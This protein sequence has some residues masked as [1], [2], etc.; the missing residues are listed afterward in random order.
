MKKELELGSNQYKVKSRRF[1]IKK[2]KVTALSSIGVIAILFVLTLVHITI[3]YIDTH[4]FTWQSPIVVKTQTPLI[5]ERNMK[6]LSPVPKDHGIL[7]KVEAQE[8]PEIDPNDVNEFDK[9]EVKAYVKQ[10]T[11]K[12]FGIEFWPS[13]F[14]LVFNESGFNILA[15]NPESTAFGMF[16]FLDTTWEGYNCEKTVRLEKQVKC[17][18]D[19]I[20]KRYGD[21]DKA[22]AFW[23]ENNWY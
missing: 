12:R 10:E 13:M 5:I 6:L 18:L 19:Y 3:E 16:Q 9:A 4:S 8:I 23:N 20:E 17:G 11:I 15:Q 22:M 2:R 21:P 1:R 7:G 14:E